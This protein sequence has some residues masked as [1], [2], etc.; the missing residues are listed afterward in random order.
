MLYQLRE[1]IDTMLIVY[2]HSVIDVLLRKKRTRNSF[3][4]IFEFEIET[5]F[6]EDRGKMIFSKFLVL[7]QLALGVKC[8]AN[9]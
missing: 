9:L 2:C 5:F 6:A 1:M 4:N 8:Q 7:A 3:L